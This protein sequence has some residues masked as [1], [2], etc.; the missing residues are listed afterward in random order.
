MESWTRVDR[1]FESKHRAGVLYKNGVRQQIIRLLKHLK[2][3]AI[4]AL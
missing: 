3:F 1:D 4:K 2:A